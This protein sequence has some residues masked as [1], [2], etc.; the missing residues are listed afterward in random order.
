VGL[1]FVGAGTYV[2][3]MRVGRRVWQHGDGPPRRNP[4]I[5]LFDL[6]ALDRSLKVQFDRRQCGDEFD[7]H[8]TCIRPVDAIRRVEFG[9]VR[10]SFNLE[11]KAGG[12]PST[13]VAR[14]HAAAA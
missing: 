10:L 2:S 5:Q 1:G 12:S 6:P 9:A 4:D 8:S 13:D 7:K 14:L 3:G 11:P